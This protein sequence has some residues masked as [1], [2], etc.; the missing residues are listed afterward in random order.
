VV[1]GEGPINPKTGFHD[2]ATVAYAYDPATNRRRT[3]AAMD[4]GR[5]G[6]L[7]AGVVWTGTK[8]LLWGGG[9]EALGQGIVAPH[10]LAYDPKRNRWH[11]LPGA[12]LLPRGNAAAVWTGKS[13]IV[14]GGELS[15]PTTTSDTW[16]LMDG[17]TF[18]PIA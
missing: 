3:L 9:S 12:P 6:R 11:Q 5:Y 8:L 18:T 2:L 17:A 4:N 15:F 1:A 10:G 16:P 14:W 7:N 13:L